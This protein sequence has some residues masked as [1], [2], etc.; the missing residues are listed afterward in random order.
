M[1][2]Q[3]TTLVSIENWLNLRNLKIIFKK[4][5]TLWIKKRL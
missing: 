3:K 2:I 1:M 5:N 4:I